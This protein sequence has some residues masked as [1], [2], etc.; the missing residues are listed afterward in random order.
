MLNVTG[1]V[2]LN[3]SSVQSVKRC[4]MCSQIGVL[5]VGPGQQDNEVLI[6]K[7]EYGSVRYVA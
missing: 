5:Y 1:P 3:P 2:P 6:L 7:N 4:V